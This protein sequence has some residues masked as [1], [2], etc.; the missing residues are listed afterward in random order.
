MKNQTNYNA[1][2]FA[3]KIALF[4]LRLKGYRFVS[5]NYVTGRGTG[6]GEIDLIVEKGQMLVFVEVKK[7]QTLARAKEAIHFQN[8]QRTIRGAESFLRRNRKYAHHQLRFDAICFDKKLWPHHI[9]N[10]WQ[11]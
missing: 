8:R 11:A 6:A 4:Y 2:H 9:K 1:G 10:A 7:R 3:E 5:L